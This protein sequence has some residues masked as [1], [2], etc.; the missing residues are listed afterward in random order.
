MLGIADMFEK[1]FFVDDLGSSHKKIVAY[2]K[3][4]TKHGLEPRE[5]CV[6]GDNFY[7]DLLSARARGYNCVLISS[8]KKAGV[9][10]IKSIYD[11]MSI[12]I[13]IN[14]ER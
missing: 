13:T 9:F 2:E 6:V 8:Q 10:S 7:V 5:I 12:E 3:I 1:T 4:R 11:L 14:K